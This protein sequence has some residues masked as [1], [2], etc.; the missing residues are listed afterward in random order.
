M[1]VSPRLEARG[2]R[3]EFALRSALLRRRIGSVRA[4]DGV[5]LDLA[6]GETV[7]LVGESGSGKTTF[8]RALLRLVEPTAGTIRFRGEDLLALRGSALRRQRRHLQ[9]VFQD[10]W[11]S[12]NP[13]L[14]VADALFEPMV[15]HGLASRRE[16]AERVARMLEE[17]GL[18]ADAGARYPNEFS[19]GQR[20][21]IGI[22]RALATDPEVVVAD[23][24]VSALDVSVRA[25]IV[26]L[27]AELQRRRGL[28]MLFIAHDLAVVE[29]IADRVAV[30][31]LGRVVEQGPARE[32]LARPEHPYTVALLSAVPVPDP[33]RQRAARIVL[34]GD[35]PNPAA[36]PPGCPFHPR[37]PIAR[38]LCQRE[39]PALAESDGG[40][41][42][43][44]HF[45]GELGPPGPAAG[46]TFPV[47]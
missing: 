38:E 45:P 31:Y 20:Q 47:G 25:Q 22:A 16:K 19:G 29:Q 7:G 30:L 10:P 23:E 36:P 2:V 41:H 32:L 12:L 37:C 33:S 4:V 27:L 14:R 5:D 35:P 9:M 42:V 18:P 39:L 6:A 13:R 43:A 40:R 3:V 15:I 11:G 24:P 8:A 34:P 44:C 28:S 21:R 46:G 26:N 17:V 1:N